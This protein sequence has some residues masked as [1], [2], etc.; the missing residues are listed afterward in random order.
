M[1]RRARHLSQRFV[2]STTSDKR[3][4]SFTV[5]LKPLQYEFQ[6]YGVSQRIPPE[7]SDKTILAFSVDSDVNRRKVGRRSRLGRVVRSGKGEAR[8]L[9]RWGASLG[10]YP[11]RNEAPKSSS[12][13]LQFKRHTTPVTFLGNVS[14]G[15]LPASTG[16]SPPGRR[17][18]R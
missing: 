10:R 1:L 16:K 15:A 2:V 11:L 9:P 14:H 17:R 13:L 4:L 5:T 7:I 12:D 18:G 6:R 3:P 8:R